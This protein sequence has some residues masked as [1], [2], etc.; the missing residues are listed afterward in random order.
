MAQPNSLRAS[1]GTPSTLI[2]GNR[3]LGGIYELL[4]SQDLWRR[5]SAGLLE[6]GRQSDVRSMHT[7]LDLG[8]GPGESTFALAEELGDAVTVH[9]IDKHV[10]MVNRAQARAR[11]LA[12]GNVS[13]AVADARRLDLASSTVDLVVGH[14]FLYLIPPADRD[15]VLAEATR[16]LRPGGRLVLMEPNADGSVLASLRH[17]PLRQ[18]IGRPVTSL[19]FATSLVLWRVVSG[20]SG[21]PTRG[22]L[23][24]RFAHAGL[25]SITITP[26]LGNLGLFAA[27][28]KK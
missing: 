12:C 26:T 4:T 10:A 18:A 15:A 16:V 17:A 27:G 9:G 6:H 7:V 1:R 23:A 21:R 5:H 20:I 25:E 19:R 3:L 11:R 8:C 2:F 13:F 24:R 14:S 22:E 28:H